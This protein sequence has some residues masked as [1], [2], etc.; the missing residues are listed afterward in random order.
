MIPSTRF[1]RF[2]LLTLG[3]ILL[4]ILWG[5]YV[6]ATGSGA[7]CGSHWPLCNGEIIPREPSI[8]TMIEYSHRTTSGLALLMVIA[9]P[10][11]A[12]KIT[13]PGHQLRRGAWATLILMLT[14]A[15]VGAGLVLFELVA[16]NASMARAMFMGTH[17]TNTLLLIGALTLTA[18]FAHGG[19]GIALR[20]S[21]PLARLALITAGSLLVVGLSGAIAA[22]GDTLYPAG[23][24]PATLSAT[25]QLLIQLRTLHPFLAVAG[26]CVALYFV[27]RVR[28]SSR[29]RQARLFANVLNVMVLVQVSIGGLNLVLH[30][31]IG[32]QLLHL[33]LANCV[34]ISF[35]LTA[36]AALPAS[37]LAPAGAAV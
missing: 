8:E 19:E 22:L 20:R 3:F 18:Y 32:M 2:T 25:S 26:A 9:L 34:W 13:P 37:R 12:R 23:T 15:A 29:S 4:V 28:K 30:A 14:E 24:A 33:L 1:A 7:G 17:L 10:L 27:A 31:P 6:R 5:A 11:W 16:D 21:D 35:I 36:A